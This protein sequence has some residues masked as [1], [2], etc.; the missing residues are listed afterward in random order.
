[1]KVS[2]IGYGFVGSALE[3]A[4]IN[5]EKCVIDPKFNTEIEDLRGFNPDI[6]FICVPTPMGNN[7]SQ[8]LTIATKVLKNIKKLSL[9][10]LVVMKSSIVPSKAKEMSSIIDRFV[11]NPEF[12]REKHAL[13]DF[14]NSELILFGG[15]ETHCKQL[16]DFYSKHTICKSKS[17]SFTD[18]ICASLCKYTINSFLATKVIFFN[19]I[20]DVFD[21]SGTNEEWNNFTKI[22]S[23]DTRI[24]NSHMSVPGHDGRKGFGGACF[25]KDTSALLNYSKSINEEFKL[26]KK[27]I[28]FNNI[29]RVDYNELTNR[30]KEQKV[31]FKYNKQK[32]TG[33]S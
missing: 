13:E 26:L 24:G 32:D 22:L 21:E 11:Y 28:K 15:Q 1:M 5:V 2:I 25:P 9:Q 7:G 23:K 12:L 3:K 6:I 29:I 30:E 10:S 18:V 4:L 31:S 16:A 14:I 20:R 33:E 17:Y 8:D 19:Q 27:V